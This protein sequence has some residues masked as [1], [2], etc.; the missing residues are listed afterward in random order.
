MFLTATERE[1]DV[2][3]IALTYFCFASAVN[4]FKDAE[5]I[6]DKKIFHFNLFFIIDVS[7]EHRKREKNHQFL[8]CL[9]HVLLSHIVKM[10]YSHM[11]Y[12][13]IHFSHQLHVSNE[14]E[15]SCDDIH[16]HTEFTQSLLNCIL[17]NQLFFLLV[18]HFFH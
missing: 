6:I 10:L 1:R 5:K 18:T 16:K 7:Q 3:V 14:S 2:H 9:F 17:T 4:Y 12:M 11:P 8:V 13:K 15:F